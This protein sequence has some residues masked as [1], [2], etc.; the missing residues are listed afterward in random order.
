MSNFIGGSAMTKVISYVS[1]IGIVLTSMC[2][3]THVSYAQDFYAEKTI[4]IVV[5]LFPA[6]GG[7]DTYSRIM[8]AI[9]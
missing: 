6:G 9:A 2:S 4:R 7:F 8:A 5:G 3:S 1:L